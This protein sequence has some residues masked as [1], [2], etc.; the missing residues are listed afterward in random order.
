MIILKLIFLPNQWVLF[1]YCEAGLVFVVNSP[2]NCKNPS[3]FWHAKPQIL[4]TAMG[5]D[6][7]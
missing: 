7:K 4:V 2:P 5:F 6:A 1:K 3:F